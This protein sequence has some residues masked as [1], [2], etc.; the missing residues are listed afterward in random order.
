MEA[1]AEVEFQ[2]LRA[3]HALRCMLCDASEHRRAVFAEINYNRLQTLHAACGA[4][5]ELVV[6]RNSAGMNVPQDYR[7]LAFSNA[8][9]CNWRERLKR[10]LGAGDFCASNFERIE[11]LN[12]L[13][14]EAFARINKSR[15]A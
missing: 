7:A 14:R 15:T 5:R 10:E 6:W 1:F 8:T 12:E 3:E 4:D 2:E 13:L 11:E 9:E